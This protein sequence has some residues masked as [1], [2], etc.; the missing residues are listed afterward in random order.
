MND[1]GTALAKASLINN[2]MLSMDDSGI[3]DKFGCSAVSYNINALSTYSL[4]SNKMLTAYSREVYSILAAVMMAI[5]YESEIECKVI[6]SL[7]RQPT[8]IYIHSRP[9]Q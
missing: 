5:L 7:H 8:I 4:A 1:E 6:V 3:T 9:E 2:T